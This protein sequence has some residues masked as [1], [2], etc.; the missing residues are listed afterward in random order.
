MSNYFRQ[1]LG[2]LEGPYHDALVANGYDDVEILTSLTEDQL[3]KMFATIGITKQGHQTVLLNK[4]ASATAPKTTSTRSANQGPSP[5]HPSALGGPL[6][7]NYDYSS[8][9]L[10]LPVTTHGP[11]PCDYDSPNV[12]VKS[13][14]QLNYNMYMQSFNLPHG[15]QETSIPVEAPHLK[16]SSK[17]SLAERGLGEHGYSLP[18]RGP[19]SPPSEPSRTSL[20]APLTFDDRVGKIPTRENSS[21]ILGPTGRPSHIQQAPRLSPP[22]PISLT[23]KTNELEAEIIKQRDMNICMRK[24]LA[25]SENENIKLKESLDRI[26]AG[27]LTTVHRGANIDMDELLCRTVVAEVVRA[28]RDELAARVASLEGQRSEDRKDNSKIFRKIVRPM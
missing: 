9:P 28:E 2:C 10:E 27:G 16:Y 5:H 26:A 6:S 17:G 3:K 20:Y 15:P 14:S 8:Q 18:P 24:S 13:L 22:I 25:E 21:T 12:R 4:I 11:I 19:L 7:P 1:W 23:E